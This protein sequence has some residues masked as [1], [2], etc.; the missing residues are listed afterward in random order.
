MLKT[1]ECGTNYE[2]LVDRV[3]K[4]LFGK[5]DY[6]VKVEEELFLPKRMNTVL[7]GRYAL[8]S[9]VGKYLRLCKRWNRETTFSNDRFRTIVLRTLPAAVEDQIRI[10]GLYSADVSILYDR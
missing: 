2:E 7:E 5:S 3:V 1:V 6:V 10:E 4:L 9:L 8:K